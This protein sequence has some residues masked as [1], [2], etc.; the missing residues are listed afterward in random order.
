MVNDKFHSRTTGKNQTITHQPTQ[1]RAN[2]GGLRLGEMERDSL[3]AHGLMYFV[4]ESFMDR[5][6]GKASLSENFYIYVSKQ[7]GLIV[8]YNQKFKYNP[9]DVPYISKIHIPYAM[10]QFI[11]ECQ[12][13]NV[14]LRLFTD[15]HL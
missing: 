7:S 6:D 13:Q 1:G 15:R 10:K 4:T 8:P 3:L 14:V 5:S 12:A 2:N 9:E 11:Y